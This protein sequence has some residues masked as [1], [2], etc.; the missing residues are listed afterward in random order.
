MLY[1][2]VYRPTMEYKVTMSVPD[3][4]KLG[5]DIYDYGEYYYMLVDSVEEIADIDV[6]TQKYEVEILES[7]SSIS[8]SVLCNV[9][10]AKKAV[11][12]VTDYDLSVLTEKVQKLLDDSA[13]SRGY[14]NIVS[15]CSYATST[16]AFGEEAQVTVDWRNSVWSYLFTLQDD[17]RSGEVGQKTI[18]EILSELPIR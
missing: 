15:E 4:V 11:S 6:L 17:I 14:D 13:R 9:R 5:E 12:E 1:L 2:E 18:V 16:G 7:I 8:N 10:T 3:D